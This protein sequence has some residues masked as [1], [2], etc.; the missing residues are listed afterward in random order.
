M[1]SLLYTLLIV[2]LPAVL[3]GQDNYD[4][5][6]IPGGRTDALKLRSVQDGV[7]VGYL[8]G[9]DRFTY[10]LDTGE[11]WVVIDE[12]INE[13]YSD[14]KEVAA[15]AHAIYLTYFTKRIYKLDLTTGDVSLRLETPRSIQDVIARG[16]TLYLMHN[17]SL[18]GS[19]WGTLNVLYPTSSALIP[20]SHSGYNEL[21]EYGNDFL[22]DNRTDSII[23][24]VDDE[25]NTLIAPQKMNFDYRSR[26]ITDRRKLYYLRGG[27]IDE[28]VDLG[29]TWTTIF[30][31]PTGGSSKISN[32]ITVVLSSDTLT[33]FDLTTRS[34]TL[35]HTFLG[36]RF[37]NGI[38]FNAQ[39]TPIVYAYATDSHL[40]ID[41]RGAHE[42]PTAIDNPSTKRVIA[43]DEN[44][45]FFENTKPFSFFATDQL[46]AETQNFKDVYLNGQGD[47]I[48][49]NNDTVYISSD[50]GS[51]FTIASTTNPVITGNIRPDTNGKL[52][53]FNEDYYCISED[54][55][56]T[57]YNENRR[58]YFTHFT[59]NLE[60]L[61]HIYPVGD[62]FYGLS[63]TANVL[64]MGSQAATEHADFPWNGDQRYRSVV[65]NSETDPF[66]L[67]SENF[68]G[69]RVVLMRKIGSANEEEVEMPIG[70]SRL[71]I[72]DQ[73]RLYIRNSKQIFFSEDKGDSWT[74]IT[75]NLPDSISITD[76]D[77]ARDGTIYVASSKTDPYKLRR[78]VT[79]H[80]H[81]PQI[82]R[83]SG[84]LYPN[85]ANDL[86]HIKHL[87][88]GST[89]FAISTPMGQLVMEGE[90]NPGH[91]IEISALPNGSYS[92]IL[93]GNESPIVLP[94]VK[95]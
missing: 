36:S 4:W 20:S 19:F 74:E 83:F 27:R 6:A 34:I 41:S 94:F 60:G 92:L 44:R 26:F 49:T 46:W 67:F 58:N 5:E 95:I 48:A 85:P 8:E 9:K 15:S 71:N 73:D 55:G 30:D 28:S 62:K 11:T 88:P 59:L 39:G 75:G 69:G 3:V 42:L 1:K 54:D 12:K 53:V 33:V 7:F 66:V 65:V 80:A 56:Y 79:S 70:A 93:V 57:W 22:L 45:A 16:D 35:K 17:D 90:L 52:Y 50:G 77:V 84:S 87:L 51:T 63:E 25:L 14:L 89:H 68:G 38:H 18:F 61:N 82:N 47:F 40:R 13:D 29:L 2:L 24:I 43:L 81:Q 23:T 32:G 86:L 10:S 37:F 91:Q 31:N 64:K 72:D 76:L 21:Q 78:G